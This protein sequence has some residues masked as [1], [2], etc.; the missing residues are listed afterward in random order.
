MPGGAG[1][2][3]KA[4]GRGEV[5]GH[6]P[7]YAPVGPVRIA[8]AALEREHHDLV[9]RVRVLESQVASLQMAAPRGIPK[10]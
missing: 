4:D 6:M 1:V 9:R 3:L 2:K 5:E 7:E 10:P 8:N